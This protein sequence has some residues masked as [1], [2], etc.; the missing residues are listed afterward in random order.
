MTGKQ[1]EVTAIHAG[2]ECGILLERIPGCDMVS[3]GPT[4]LGAHSPDE[5]LDVSTVAPFWQATLNLMK[6]L[7]NEPA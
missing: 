7:A 6:A 3:Y 2:L 1:P 5:R 4:I